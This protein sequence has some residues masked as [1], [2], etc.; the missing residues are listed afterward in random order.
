M[1]HSLRVPARRRRRG[2]PNLPDY[3]ETKHIYHPET[4]ELFGVL[5]AERIPTDPKKLRAFVRK[6]KASSPNAI[7]IPAGNGDGREQLRNQD[8]WPNLQDHRFW[9][10][11]Q[12]EFER[13]PYGVNADS[14]GICDSGKSI[15]TPSLGRQLT[16]DAFTRLAWGAI[17]KLREFGLPSS[18]DPVEVWLDLAKSN[19]E[20]TRI[21]VSSTID[22]NGSLQTT[23]TSHVECI[24]T[25]S[26]ALCSTLA[27]Q[28][29]KNDIRADQRRLQTSPTGG[30][31]LCQVVQE[32]API[33]R[34]PEL[35]KLQSRT[36]ENPSVKRRH[37]RYIL[38]DRAL[39]EIGES[40]PRTQ[41][42]VFQSLDRRSVP[43]PMAE[44]FMAAHGWNSGYRLC[45]AA[46]RAWLS[47]RWAELKL[48]LL[49][50]GPKKQRK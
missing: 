34:T 31:D 43:I 9:K 41:E 15:A 7:A 5:A 27:T 10:E 16:R 44:P 21:I 8:F 2:R 45:P 6:A 42:E 40:R 23:M 1:S 22:Q 33:L 50:R 35:P 32:A 30:A 11:L 38:I 26:V 46:A 20:F 29:L 13:L 17:D 14:T 37:Q 47:K 19:R 28:A 24:R 48:P 3:I 39:R 36:N 18:A 4:G 49:P 12:T 25:A